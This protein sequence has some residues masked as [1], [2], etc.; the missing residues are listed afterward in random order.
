[1]NSL[2]I[3]TKAAFVILSKTNYRT[4]ILC[5]GNDYRL[6]LVRGEF[7]KPR[8]GDSFSLLR[9][10]CDFT[11]KIVE[12]GSNIVSLDRDIIN[13]LIENMPFMNI[14]TNLNFLVINPLV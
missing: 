11:E 7:I 5:N 13:N 1:M 9:D 12:R 6:Y 4:V 8:V 14:E 2:E 10:A 3:L